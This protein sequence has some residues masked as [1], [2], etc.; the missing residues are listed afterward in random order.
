MLFLSVHVTP[1]TFELICIFNLRGVSLFFFSPSIFKLNSCKYSCEFLI[2]KSIK[3]KFPANSMSAFYGSYLEF[4]VGGHELA[5]AL[6]LQKQTNKQTKTTSTVIPPSSAS[7]L[8]FTVSLSPR[9]NNGIDRK[10][11]P[12]RSL[13]L[14]SLLLREF[15]SRHYNILHFCLDAGA[16]TDLTTFQTID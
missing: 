9:D 12:D 5:R 10:T 1:G 15:N 7:Q 16:R 2:T 8:L 6:I 14:Y 11:L 3:D 13:N 4:Y